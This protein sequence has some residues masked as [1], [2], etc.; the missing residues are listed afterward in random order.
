MTKFLI[1]TLLAFGLTISADAQLIRPLYVVDESSE[2]GQG[3]VLF[4]IDPHTGAV[5]EPIGDTGEALLAIAVDQR[6]GEVIGLTASDSANPNSLLRIDPDNGTVTQVIPLVMPEGEPVPTYIDMF[7]RVGTA[8]QNGLLFAS[9]IVSSNGE[10]FT[11]IHSLDP[12][13]GEVITGYR[14]GVAQLLPGTRSALADKASVEIGGGTMFGCEEV[15]VDSRWVSF[16]ILPPQGIPIDPPPP[17]IEFQLPD[18]TCVTAGTRLTGFVFFGVGAA[19]DGSADRELIRIDVDHT[20][21]AVT[22]LG[23]LPDNTIGIAFGPV[24]ASN[25]PALGQPAFLLLIAL[26]F[27]VAGAA[28]ARTGS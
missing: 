12:E 14:T 20:S 8:D 28:R 10:S 1:P 6:T 16:L 26:V 5:L 7:F 2:P 15:T 17:G 19:L 22:A 25:V 4:H 11:R 3:S 27:I 18:A 24:P 9:A 23:A 13:T 21:A